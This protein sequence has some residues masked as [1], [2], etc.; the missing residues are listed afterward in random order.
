MV[1]KSDYFILE[2]KNIQTLST[3]CLEKQKKKKKKKKSVYMIK[4][5]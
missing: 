5:K 3:S 4:V 2:C 1:P